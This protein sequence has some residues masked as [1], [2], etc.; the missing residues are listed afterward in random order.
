MALQETHTQLV[1]LNTVQASS[2]R[3]ELWAG[4]ARIIAARRSLN[5]KTYH[6][7]ILVG[8]DSLSMQEIWKIIILNTAP[9]GGSLQVVWT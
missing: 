8:D 7:S 1:P 2:A 6:S 3:P 4:P 5:L 9:V